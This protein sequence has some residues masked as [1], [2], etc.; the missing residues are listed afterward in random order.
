[1]S[2]GAHHDLKSPNVA[3]QLLG[4]LPDCSRKGD[5]LAV[6][7]WSPQ[8]LIIHAGPDG[9][10]LIAGGVLLGE[11]LGE[12]AVVG[13]ESSKQVHPW[14]DGAWH[15]PNPCCPDLGIPWHPVKEHETSSLQNPGVLTSGVQAHPL[16]LSRHVPPPA[17][18]PL[19]LH[20]F[21]WQDW[22]APQEKPGVEA[23]G[24]QEQPPAGA[25]W[26]VA[27]PSTT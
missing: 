21:D 7:C 3:W 25:P 2:L 6:H 8:N 9:V 13:L 27:W 10:G 26:H 1:M 23:S 4:P 17:P 14:C 16:K 5:V 15:T 24:T 12:A 11:L 22:A 19:P 20:P 18:S